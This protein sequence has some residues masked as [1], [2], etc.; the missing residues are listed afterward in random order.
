MNADKLIINGCVYI[1]ETTEP[2]KRERKRFFITKQERYCYTIESGM[3]ENLFGESGY[4]TAE[5]FDGEIIISKE[6]FDLATIKVGGFSS[7]L[8]QELKQEL[9]K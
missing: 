2:V 3:D 9:F 8:I 4:K 1:K 6:D 5:L 7:R